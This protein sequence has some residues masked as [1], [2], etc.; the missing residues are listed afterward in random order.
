MELSAAVLA[1]RLDRMI[2]QEV[3]LPIDQS[4]FWTDS[5]CVLRYI[6]GKD[7]RFQTFVTNRI[8]AI[9]DQST[10]TQWRHVDTIQNPADEASRRLQLKHC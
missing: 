9:L 7:K 10:A 6:K 8:S 2:E 5:S 4:T 3:T 1:T